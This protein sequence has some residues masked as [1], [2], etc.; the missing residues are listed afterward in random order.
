MNDFINVKAFGALGNGIADDSAAINSALESGG[1]IYI[2]AGDYLLAD[3]LKVHSHTHITADS[4]ARLFRREHTQTGRKDF[5]LTNADTGN[6]NSDISIS[7]GTWDGNCF[8]EDRGTDLFDPAATTGVLLN[9]RNVKNLSLSGM[10]LKNALCYYTRFCE[11]ENVKIE[12]I[13]FSSERIVANQDGIHLAGYCKGFEIKNLYGEY[14]S[15]NDDFI[16]L[17]ADDA[18]QRQECFDTINGPIENI[19]VQNLHSDFCHCFVRLLSVHNKIKNVEISN[20]SGK[21][22]NRAINLD[23][24]RNCRVKLFD[25]ND[26]PD[27]VGKIE[28]VLI[29]GITVEHNDE[30]EPFIVLETNCKN[31]TVKNY[32]SAGGPGSFFARVNYTAAYHYS[33]KSDGN[34]SEK[35]HTAAQHEDIYADRVE[36][37]TFDTHPQAEKH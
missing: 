25:N 7:G 1:N 33:L 24:A 23:A 19:T 16:A 4:G 13:R 27:G 18:M 5:L 26:F 21:C 17:N 14:G 30:T 12:N 11:A 9:F 31:F 15:P 22:R 20:V 32:S 2:P 29:D 37:F 3:T 36:S 6:G 8:K 28:N 10:I 34:A 35:E